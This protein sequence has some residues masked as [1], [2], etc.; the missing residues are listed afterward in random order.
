MEKYDL[1]PLK[2]KHHSG[3]L[4]KRK[5]TPTLLTLKVHTKHLDVLVYESETS[6]SSLA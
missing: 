2:I 1:L 4:Q 5:F 6:A 3:D